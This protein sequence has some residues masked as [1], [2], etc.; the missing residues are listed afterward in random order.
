MGKIALLLLTVCM[1]LHAY[2]VN[3]LTTSDQDFSRI[4]NVKTFGSSL[5]I[6]NTVLCPKDLSG[7]CIES[8]SSNSSLNLQYITHSEANLSIPYENFKVLKA[9]LFWQGR[10]LESTSSATATTNFNNALASTIKLKLPGA[11]TFTTI[12]LGTSDRLDKYL[13]SSN[14]YYM[15]TYGTYTD[16]TSIINANNPQGL[17]TITDLYTQTGNSADGLGYF[18]AWSMVFV[19]EDLSQHAPVRDISVYNGYKVINSTSK[20]T[21]NIDGFLTPRDEEKDVNAELTLF[22][23][24][25]DISI[26]GDQLKL[27]EGTATALT[28]DG[29]F[30]NITYSGGSTN[31]VFASNISGTFYR[32]PSLTN[33]NAIDLHTIEV[34]K[35][36]SGYD[37]I[38]HNVSQAAIRLTSTQDAYFASMAI[39][40]VE[41]YAPQFCYDYAYSQNGNYFTED[42]NGSFDPY[43]SGQVAS[44]NNVEVTLYVRNQES[45]LVANNAYLHVLDINTTQAS[46]ASSGFQKTNAGAILYYT[47]TPN[48]ATS[49]DFNLSLAASMAPNQGVYAK[50]MLDPV[51]V[52][53]LNVSLNAYF[54]YDF[55]VNG[56]TIHL[57]MRKLTRDIPLCAV[58]AYNY[59]P[60][61]GIFNALDSALNLN[62]D[63]TLKSN[64]K[65]NLFTQVAKRPFSV[66]IVGFDAQN[67]D[68]VKAMQNFIS[69]EL[70]DAGGFHDLQAACSDYSASSSKKVWMAFINPNDPTQPVTHRTFDKNYIQAAIDAGLTNVTTPEEFYEQVHENTAFRIWYQEIKD[71]DGNILNPTFGEFQDEPRVAM[72]FPAIVQAYSCSDEKLNVAVECGSNDSKGVT[73]DF[74]KRCM[75]CIFGSTAM[76]LCSRDNFAVRP[77]S[78]AIAISDY[79]HTST[80]TTTQAVPKNAQLAAGYAYRF[81]INATSHTH[82]AATPGYTLGFYQANKSDRNITFNWT[83]QTS[84]LNCNDANSSTPEFFMNNGAITNQTRA[85]TNV[86]RYTLSMVDSSF[87]KADQNPTHHTG[88]YFL[89]GSD[90][91]MGASMVP[92]STTAINNTNIGCNVASSHTNA[93]YPALSTQDYNLTFVPFKLN[94][95]DLAPTI[96]ITQS[97]LTN[98]ASLYMSDLATSTQ[99]ALHYAGTL[100]VVGE[101]NATLTNFTQGCYATDVRLHLD[102]NATVGT[103]PTFRVRYDD[104]N[105]SHTL[106]NNITP[107][108]T[109][110][111]TIPASYFTKANAGTL[112]MQLHLNFD[113]NRTQAV[114]MQRLHFGDMNSSCVTATQ[115][116][117]YANLNTTYQPVDTIHTD[118]N[119]TFMYGRLHAPRYRIEGAQSNINLYYEV[120]CDADSSCT[121]GSLGV[122]LGTESLDDVNWYVNPAHTSEALFGSII[123]LSGQTHTAVTTFGNTAADV[124]FT[125]GV[126]TTQVVYDQT[127]GFPFKSKILLNTQPW[128]VYHRFDANATTNSMMLEFFNNNAGWSG[129]S[130][131][132]SNVDEKASKTTNRRINW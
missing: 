58:G 115:C 38:G 23:G 117:S 102:H 126:K 73:L 108:S 31:N 13:Y 86:G 74:Y 114:P 70:I 90:C 78:F 95:E 10:A 129:T 29:D 18:G 80:V 53:D 41:L 105:T 52:L 43:I 37:I 127:L 96:G 39:F 65:Y 21:I 48:S 100:R 101:D 1:S 49:S 36:D 4:Y 85:H 79:D 54:E 55:T 14:G 109:P 76:P 28:P 3:D 83:P 94:I 120:F 93:D 24:E 40:S 56:S 19:V 17:Y 26:T 81:D 22:A 7:V 97:P 30:E 45:D 51:N 15:Y 68:E 88:D 72:D 98:T 2:T 128:L 12:T 57:P 27:K 132:S 66:E 16:I 107:A 104:A 33:N 61:W 62:S 116:Q 123:S 32:N 71:Q 35:N 111:A 75:E 121:N 122:A 44:G 106:L 91:L 118:S 8:T 124:N 47:T 9:Y 82:H 46:I 59:V 131:T 92:S 25:G 60:E 63:G 130:K 84:G 125:Q 77:E 103:T 6:G 99:M 64:L 5:A 112:P 87:T 89:S 42:N 11:S 67:L 110:L 20:A 113:R 50:F 69:I 119:V 34:G